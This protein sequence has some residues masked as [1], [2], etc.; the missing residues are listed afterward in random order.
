M[1]GVFTADADP[2]RRGRDDG[3]GPRGRAHAPGRRRGWPRTCAASW[4]AP[5]GRRVTLL[6][7]AG[8]NGGDALW[9][10]ADL[11]RR[12]APSPRCCWSRTGRTATGLAALRRAGGRV[13]DGA[14]DAAIGAVT[15]ADL[16]IDGIVGI[17]GTRGLREP[18]AALVAAADDAR[19]PDR[20]VRPAERRRH[21][22]RRDRRP[23]RAGRVDRHVRRAQAGA[24]AGRAALRAVHLVDFGLG[25]F[26]PEPH[27]YRAAGDRRGRPL[28]G[29][30]AVRRQVHP[31]R[32][33][34]RGRLGHL[35]GRRRAR[36]RRRGAGHVRHGPVRRARPRTT[37]AR[38]G[39]RSWPPA[40]ITDA[41]RT[42]AWVVGPGMGTGSQRPSVLEACWTARCRC[43]STR[44]PSRCSPATPT[45]GTPG[46]TDAAVVLTPH[47]REFARIAGPT[48]GTDRVAA[49][50]RAAGELNADGA[51]QGQRDGRRG[52]G[53]AGAGQ[54]GR[55]R[56]G[57][58]GRVRGRA[59]RDDRRAA[60]GRA[61]ALVGRRVRDVRARPG[62]HRG[63]AG[64]RVAAV[65]APASRMQAAIPEAL[66]AVRGAAGVD[67]LGHITRRGE[68]SARMR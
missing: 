54:P 57:R 60:R 13:V 39:R 48:S 38:A 22:H 19:R 41:G 24:R 66:R 47:D 31:G 62:G 10:G 6:V 56:V 59:D 26:L 12:G 55:G 42:Q 65:P 37:S 34:D 67:D 49:A 51:A 4:A 16:V 2:R 11:R 5:Y 3:D 50:R 1:D 25:P 15:R 32:R 33:R 7:G 18:G 9:A 21:G 8:N 58:D 36:R 45:C 63:R 46:S 20:R 64:A 43:A 23:A 40:T 61:G 52:P 27:A 14:S 28:A 53:R 44:T 29:A 17:S 68:R 35:P 30:R